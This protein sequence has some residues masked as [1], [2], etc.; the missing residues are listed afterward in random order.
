MQ[1]EVTHFQLY[2]SP[3]GTCVGVCACVHPQVLWQRVAALPVLYWPWGCRQGGSGVALLV[4]DREGQV[5][6]VP[7]HCTVEMPC[8]PLT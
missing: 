8:L 7:A 3:K 6:L 2:P 4:W 5:L 1:R